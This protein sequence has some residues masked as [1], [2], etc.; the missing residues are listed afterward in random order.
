M[1]NIYKFLLI[2]IVVVIVAYGVHFYDS[3]N[4]LSPADSRP[5]LPADDKS[6][7]S[8]EVVTVEPTPDPE[9]VYIDNSKEP[10]KVELHLDDMKFNNA[11]REKMLEIYKQQVSVSY[12]LSKDGILK[13]LPSVF[14]QTKSMIFHGECIYSVDLSEVNENSFEVDNDADIITI[15]IPEPTMEVNYLPEK[16]EF[17]NASNGLLRFGDMKISA[18]DMNTIASTAMQQLKDEADSRTNDYETAKKFACLSVKE[19][20]E[21]LIRKLE[22]AI[23]KEKNDIYAIPI[24]YDIRVVIDH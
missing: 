1:K 16:T 23:V 13:Y 15:H 19:I 2:S 21:P 7:T 18:E 14:G 17:F 11:E 10:Y 8:D 4:I 20:Y 12:T 6:Y 9:V 24:N 5:E 22:D 3:L